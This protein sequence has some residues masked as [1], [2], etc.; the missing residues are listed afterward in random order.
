MNRSE[1]ISKVEIL[2]FFF[3]ILGTSTTI[4]RQSAPISAQFATKES[5]PGALTSFEPVGVE[6]SR[7]TF[8]WDLPEANGIITGFEIE[9][10]PAQSESLRSLEPKMFR[11]DFSSNERR[12]TIEN[13]TPGVRYVFQIKANTRVGEGNHF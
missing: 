8:R 2:I 11:K 1:S 3:H 13:L 6:P 9:Y 7:I 5:A 10:Y 4:R 12:G